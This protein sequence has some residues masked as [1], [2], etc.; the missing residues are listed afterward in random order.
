MEGKLGGGGKRGGERRGRKGKGGG[1]RKGEERRGREG[2]KEREEGRGG[3][4]DKLMNM[5]YSHVHIVF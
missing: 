3:K 1:R 4:K 2:G 5:G